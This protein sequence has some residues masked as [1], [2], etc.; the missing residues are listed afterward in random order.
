MDNNDNSGDWENASD[1]E[2]NN[3][4]N[5]SKLTKNPNIIRIIV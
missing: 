3:N 5:E 1:D 4:K 2:N